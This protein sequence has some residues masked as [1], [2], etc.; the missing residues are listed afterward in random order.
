MKNSIDKTFTIQLT[1]LGRTFR[2]CFLFMFLVYHPN[3]MLSQNFSNRGTDFWVGHQGHVDGTGSNFKLYI[4]SDVNT[5]GTVSVPLQGWSSAFTVIAG[6]I[7]IVQVPSATGYVGCSDCIKQ[8]G[9]HVVANDDVAVYAHIYAS[10][11][12]DATLMLP[13]VALGKEYYAMCYT[14]A[15]GSESEFMVVAPEDSTQVQITPAATTLGGQPANVPFVITLQQG[16][17]YQ[18]QSGT[19]LTGSKILSISDSGS[20][21]KVAVFAGST[22]NSLGCSGASSGDNL[23]E[24]MYPVNT[25]GKNFITSPLKTRSGD[26][27]R[28]MAG[29]NGTNFTI[30]GVSVSLNQ[31]Q[32]FDTLL[33]VPAYITSNKPITLAQYARTQNCDGATGDPFMII[34]SPVEQAINNVLLYSSPEQ[35]ITGEYINVVMKTADVGSC[36]LDGGAITFNPVPS[37]IIYSYSQNTITAGTH[38]LV[39]DSGF[40]AI[41]YGFGNIESYGYLAGANIKNL[42]VQSFTI[43]PNPACNGSTLSFTG[44]ATYTPS[45]WKWNFGDS[46]TSLLQSPT[47]IYAD[48]G[49]Y[50]VSLITDYPNGCEVRI[51]TSSYLLHVY[52]NAI[53]NFYAPPVCIWGATSLLD[54]STTINGGNL[55]FWSWDFGDGSSSVLQNTLH[56]YAVCDTFNVKLVVASN[57]GCRD[58]IIKHVIVNCLPAPNFNAAAVCDNHAMIFADSSS[59]SISIWNWDFGDGS[60][61]NTNNNPSHTFANPGIYNV[62]LTTTSVSGCIDSITK[63]V[64]V[65]YNPTAAF[66][67]SDV[68]FG[69]TIYF[70][71]T[72]T[73]DNSSS[74]AFNSWVFGDG[75]PSGSLQNASHYYSTA[76]TYTVILS[77][78]TIDG[79]SDAVT[80]PVSAF[81]KPSSAITFSNT[82]LSDTAKFTNVSLNP[83]MGTIANWSWDF[84]DGSALNTTAWSPSHLYAPPGNYQLTL[85]TYSS[86]L[87]CSDTLQ[88]SIT[89]FPMPVADFSFN[90]V[91]LYQTTNFIDLSTVSV[92]IIAGRLWNFGDGTTP[93]ANPNPPHT[94][95]NPGTYQVS[96]I[97]T[98]DN[99]CKDTIIKSVVVHPMPDAQFGI[100]NAC[101]GSDVQFNDLSTI[102]ITD[103]IQSW[104][105]NFGDGSPVVGSQ[106]T[107]HLFA[108][109][110]FD[111]VQ[112]LVVSNF[113]C[114]DSISKISIVNPNPVVNFTT[115]DT[116]GCE[117]LC[118][119]FVNLSSVATGFNTASAWNFGDG[120]ASGNLLDAF[121]CY[122]NDSLYS[123]NSFTVTL[124]VTSDSG[125]VSTLTK[126]NYITVYPSPVA[127]FTVQ[128][129]ATTITDP[130][131][132]VTNL[133][134]GGNFWTWNFGDQDTSFVYDPASHTYPDTGSYTITLITSTQYNCAD[135]MFHAIVIEPD[136][137]FYIPNAFTPDGDGINDNFIGK[138]VFIKEFEMS[139]FDR[140]GNLIYHTN[141]INKP[142]NGKANHGTEMAQADVY[143]YKISVTDYNL[144][145][146]PYKGIVTL[147]R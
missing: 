30:N 114:V 101:D 84:G 90:N 71:N 35:N 128:P 145:K 34:L 53:A 138:G 23:Y 135:T 10:A 125:C 72:S 65:Y 108:D 13:T 96:L 124:T 40:N 123:P 19:D 80:I 12:S 76:G 18:V 81:D 61:I 106:N 42:E 92:G 49:N 111:T 93:N 44:I 37:N 75:S 132:S 109:A 48:T 11:R 9:I 115:P 14:Q 99:G 29:S 119:D 5:S 24:E 32:Y 28:V 56:T 139:I 51:D 91:C 74:I 118:V 102:P 126:T 121:H 104:T 120:S 21:K 47:H 117:P 16:E 2:W 54:I 6:T 67:H 122:L 64:Q 129:Q 38:T 8:K 97:V 25:W 4:T 52:G 41:A 142:W 105:W 69:D 87:G 55:S 22:W 113:G 133:S 140:W 100:I 57:D 77:I 39:A 127:S 50:W 46:T 66:T 137:L 59:G 73:V 15:G 144:R 131:I 79:C 33:T 88:D 89:V 83:I 45:S 86:N 7:T 20:C 78:I 112:L 94:F 136:F 146:H 95:A 68:C 1:F 43:N 107:S 58:S 3:K 82:C 36:L 60:A 103:T 134:T 63:P 110:G 147:V 141:D 116:A 70:A 143:V 17:V 31:T 98:T 26:M 85:I 27:F 130:V 62:T